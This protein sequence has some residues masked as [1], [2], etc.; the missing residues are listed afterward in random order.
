MSHR[1]HLRIDRR[2]R[3]F[4]VR[5]GGPQELLMP[6]RGLRIGFAAGV[7]Q[8]STQ[9]VEDQRTP[10]QPNQASIV[11]VDQ[12]AARGGTEERIGVG[13]NGDHAIS[14]G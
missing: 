6:A 2:R 14:A 9:F 13:N 12:Q 8:R 11:E 3:D 5:Q 7:D 4:G 10:V 1:F